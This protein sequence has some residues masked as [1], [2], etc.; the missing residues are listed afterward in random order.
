MTNVDLGS[1]YNNTIIRN[2]YGIYLLNTSRI[3]VERNL[4]QENKVGIYD[5]GTYPSVDP[6]NRLLNNVFSN[7]EIAIHLVFKKNFL[8]DNKFYNNIKDIQSE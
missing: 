7:N 1:I 6:R 4:L 2:V 3:Q 8:N 5:R